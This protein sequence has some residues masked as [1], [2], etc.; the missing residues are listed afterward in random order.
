MALEIVKYFYDRPSQAVGV[1]WFAAS[2]FAGSL[3]RLVAVDLN[4]H[5]IEL[6]S[7]D[8]GLP[9]KRHFFE[10]FFCTTA[11]PWRRAFDP[12]NLLHVSVRKN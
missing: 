2:L 4:F 7:V 10:K 5:P 9:S 8:Y 1:I 12:A 11:M 3:S 6:D